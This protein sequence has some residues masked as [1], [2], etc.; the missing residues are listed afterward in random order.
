MISLTNNIQNP[1]DHFHI[2]L[3]FSFH[4][5]QILD[6]YQEILPVLKVYQDVAGHRGLG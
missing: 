2:A 5:Q 4:S 6:G 1:F 3:R